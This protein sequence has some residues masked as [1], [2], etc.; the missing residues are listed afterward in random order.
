[1]GI[2]HIDICGLSG[3]SVEAACFV[4]FV[5]IRGQIS[6]WTERQS[7]LL[8]VRTDW[9]KVVQRVL[10]L[11]VWWA[12]NKWRMLKPGYEI[13]RPPMGNQWHDSLRN[14]EGLERRFPTCYA[15]DPKVANCIGKRVA[16]DI[17]RKWINL[18]ALSWTP[19]NIVT[20]QTMY[21]IFSV[22]C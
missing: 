15:C 8:L 4:F 9:H 12:E 11:V 21:W 10:L 19:H 20:Y 6:R 1:M 2:R 18:I 7:H 17:Y 5:R 13:T 14:S 3:S 16:T 22:K